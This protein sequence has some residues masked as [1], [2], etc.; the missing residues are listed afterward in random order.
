MKKTTLILSTLLLTGTLALAG[1]FG[2]GGCGNHSES[3]GPHGNPDMILHLLDNEEL[4]LDEG[5]QDKIMQMIEADA[6]WDIDHRA[7]LE[8]LELKMQMERTAEEP[9]LAVMEKT[10]DLLADERAA[11]MKRH[12][13]TRNEIRELL[14]EKQREVLRKLTH[15]RHRK[16]ERQHP[17]G[18]HPS[19]FRGR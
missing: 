18:H 2:K 3:H 15:K 8:K 19:E 12:M 4:N 1:P 17:G 13:R 16:Q 14:T 10:I 6:L 11:G 7:R 5:Q 9:D